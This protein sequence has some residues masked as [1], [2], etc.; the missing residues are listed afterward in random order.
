MVNSLLDPLDFIVPVSCPMVR[1]LYYNVLHVLS[2]LNLAQMHHE[3]VLQI[4]QRL[5]QETWQTRVE[6]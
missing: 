5:L 4:D 6:H 3:S 1:C 2:C